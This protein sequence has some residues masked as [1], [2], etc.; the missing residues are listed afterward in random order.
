[1]AGSPGDDETWIPACL[2]GPGSPARW[3]WLQGLA[4]QPVLPLEPWL[5]ALEA[6]AVEPQSDL[7]AVLAPRLDGGSA[8]RLLGFWIREAA[9]GTEPAGLLELVGRI[10]DP[11]CAALLRRQ[12]SAQD[13]LAITC[14]LLPLLGHQRDPADFPLLRRLVVEPG[15]A[16]LRE[17]ALEGLA[18]GLSVWPQG[19]LVDALELLALDLDP[20]LAAKAVDLL[21]RLPQGPAALDRLA[22][23]CLEPSVR[24]R[25]ERRLQ[26]WRAS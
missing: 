17:A 22:L 2:P 13:S 18:V 14:A 4:R 7:L 5:L 26:G 16:R 24:R 20:G 12:L 11:L 21:A 19:E 23:R 6:G 3:P 9:E 8:A 10:R 1:M 15:P 25:L